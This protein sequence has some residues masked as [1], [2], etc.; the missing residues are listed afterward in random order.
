MGVRGEFTVDHSHKRVLLMLK[1]RNDIPPR[2]LGITKR[3][4][5]NEYLNV[6]E[7]R[8]QVVLAALVFPVNRTEIAVVT[9]HTLETFP[10]TTRKWLTFLFDNTFYFEKVYFGVSNSTK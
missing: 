5:N 9:L 4:A 6:T 8:N 3:K 2:K 1:H 7:D 10:S